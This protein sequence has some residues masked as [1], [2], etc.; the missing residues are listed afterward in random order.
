MLTTATEL[1]PTERLLLSGGDERIAVCPQRAANKYGC[2]PLPQGVSAAFGSSTA[3]SISER[4]FAA[5][6]RL[7][8]QLQR[9]CQHDAPAQVYAREL[10]RVRRELTVSC[11]LVDLP[12]LEI[13]FAAS[14]TDLHLMV[15]QMAAGLSAQPPLVIMMEG[16]ETGS[17]VASALG[18]RHFSG[19]SALGH[20][21]QAGTRIHGAQHTQL[22]QIAIRQPNGQPRPLPDLHTEVES[23]V[24]QAA[25][26]GQRVLLIMLD[27]SKTGLMAPSPDFAASLRSRWPDTVDVMVDACQFRL[28]N[29]SLRA[30]LDA[31]F[32]VAM[33]GSKFLTGPS[34]SGALFVPR[35]LAYRMAACP[36]PAGLRA[37]AARAEWPRHWAAHAQLDDVDNFGLLLR[38][39]ATLA[40][41]HAFRLVPEIRTE[42]F[43]GD[44]ARAVRQHLKDQ[45][46]FQPLPVPEIDRQAFTGQA[47]WDHI[48]TIFPFV[49]QA[50]DSCGRRVPLNRE[51][52]QRV[53]QLLQADLTATGLDLTGL[54]PELASLRCQI[55]QPVACGERD[56]VPVSALRLCA[57]ARLVVEAA[58]RH[59]TQSRAV[60]RRALATL[61]KAAW[62]AQAVMHHNDH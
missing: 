62:L 18:G 16:N 45:P 43:L 2:S 10:G 21:A 59:G 53:Y 5:A 1:L 15:A 47:G 57:S 26:A 39:Q 27:L 55:G 14:G 44:F 34:F 23:L 31:G 56:G 6:D 32:L 60:I 51:Q 42:R 28:S 46:A 25:Q 36:L 30:Y 41:L 17:S 20:E 33:T 24:A 3:S 8:H 37:Y 48:P 13:A 35:E 11:G 61:D 50:L 54:A 19:Q 40:E 12:G 22:A 38:W 29:P 7:R 49:L 58:A 9:A 4:G 52:T